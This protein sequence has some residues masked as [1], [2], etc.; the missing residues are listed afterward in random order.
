LC[1]IL[2]NK[3]NQL[4]AI[5]IKLKNEELNILQSEAYDHLWNG[6]YRMALSAAKKL[7]RERPDDSEAAICLAWALL[8]NDNPIK[9]MDYANLAVELKG[10]SIKARLYRGYLLMRMSIFE[11]AIA[12]FNLTIDKNK[13]FLAW[14][15]LNKARAFAGLNKYDEAITAL[16]LALIIDNGKNPD[17]SKLKLWYEEAKKMSS[18]KFIVDQ[19]NIAELI[20]TAKKAINA[21]EYWYA[22]LISRKILENPKIKQEKNEAE[23][24]ELESMINLFQYKPALKKAESIKSKFK[25]DQKFQDL[26]KALIKFDR[27]AEELE[28]LDQLEIELSE[29][30]SKEEKKEITRPT[31]PEIEKKNNAIYFPNEQADIF[32]AKVFDVIE[33]KKENRRTFYKQ[34]NETKISHIGVEIIFSNPM[35]RL[36]D[37]VF[38][39]CAIWYLNDFQIGKNKF[40]LNIKEEWD[41]VI[42]A[43][44]WGSDDKGIWKYGQGRVEIYIQD[45][46]VCEKWFFIGSS[47]IPEKEEA[48]PIPPSEKAK[49]ETKEIDQDS[50][51]IHLDEEKKSLDD[52]LEE[53]DSYIGL[54]SI[55]K[56]VRD[57]IDYLKF[58]EERKKLGLKSADNISLNA[59][60]L[61]NPGTGK[62]TIA[63]LLGKIFCAMG[64]L[65]KG[66]VVEV[67]RSGLVGQYIGETAQKTEKIIKDATGGILFIDEAYTLVKKGGSGQDFGQEAIDILLKRMEDKKGEFVVIAAGYPEEMNSFIN[68]NPGLKSRFTKFFTFEDYEPDELFKIFE[69]LTA[70]EEYTI[71]D[72]AS[73]ILKK[74]YMNLYRKRDKTFGNARVAR[75]FFEEAKMSLSQRYIKLDDKDKTK[76]ALTTITVADI[77]QLFTKEKE[78]EVRVPINEEAL[79]EA[80]IELESLAGLQSVKKDVRDMIKLARYYHEQGEDLNDKFCSHILFLGNP[81]TGKTT[82]ARIFGKIY[83]ALG[84]LPRGQLIEVDRQSIVASYVGQT[85]EKTTQVINESIGGTLFIDE[86]YTLV[87]KEGSGG[88]FGKEAID[89]LLKRMEDDRG[90]FICIAAG[91]T[92]EMKSFIESNPGIQSRFTKSFTFD[93]YTPDELI[94]IF[95][96]RLEKENLSLEKNAETELEKYFNEIYRKRN[97]NFGNARIVRNLVEDSLKRRLLRLANIPAEKRTDD[98]TKMLLLDDL[99]ELIS[100]KIDAKQYE[101]K[102]DQAKLDVLIKELDSLTGLDSVKQG[103]ERLINSLKVKQLRKQHG[104]QVLDKS[105]HSVFTGNPGTGKT[106]VA[107]LLSNIY[108]EIGL[109]EKGHL[110]EVDRADLVA[111]YQGQ[112]A[113]KTDKLIQSALGGTLFIDEAYTLARGNN[114]FGQEA[115][116]TLLK[117]MEDYKGQFIVIVA[118]Y[119]VEMEHFVNSNPGFQ[120]RFTNFFHFE[121]YSGRQLLEIA[122]E[123]AHS[124]GYRLDEGALQL[125]LELFT[126]LY[127]KRDKNFG[128]ARTARNILYQAISNQEGRISN[129]YDHTDENL[130]TIIFE[131][132]EKI[133]K[134]DEQP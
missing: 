53:I 20:A 49:K 56:S 30:E 57:Y 119:P 95:K 1:S 106:T 87:K 85:A 86:A 28:N 88:D 125:M 122:A 103:V 22:L 19:K 50:Y 36:E 117:R 111:G 131:D 51:E 92:D 96:E 71:D 120:S 124:N 27:Q 34:F 104:L 65:P 69:K 83:S 73:E 105:L 46:K 43:Q 16:K 118:G 32:S 58:I 9:A 6:R 62:T 121:D 26:Y 21:K 100:P 90:K 8:E 134:K 18:D 81:G 132:V 115:I 99:E 79:S 7:F 25:K 97:K 3:L 116:D 98:V 55:K 29:T 128:N 91:Y 61:G 44:T 80:T 102:I 23:I 101:I 52:L 84:I 17:W 94:S 64:I 89:T 4:P 54:K 2:D 126:E 15:Y 76:E 82:V 37:K 14:T 68:S 129:M 112:T 33:E 24:L 72:K 40:T 13:E 109:L 31:K 60:F 5:D 38:D 45:F 12:D 133:I 77:Q 47:S 39:C 78:K 123:I 66:H 70:S 130:M 10:D 113:I 48:P 75:Q 35:F 63:R 127:K 114:D 11:G 41:S 110:V 67:D 59:V 108:K 74:E 93:D 42:F 107:R